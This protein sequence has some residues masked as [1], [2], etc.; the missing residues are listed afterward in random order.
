MTASQPRGA[1]AFP[2]VTLRT[3][4]FTVMLLTASTL[5]LGQTSTHST[6]P[7]AAPSWPL[8]NAYQTHFVDRSGR[9][10]D[11]DASD[12]TTSEGQ[13]Y[14]MF[15]SLVAN[16]P[17]QFDRLLQWTVENLA[18]GD[19]TAHLPAWEWGHAPDGSWRILDSNS[20]A[21]ADLWIAYTLLQAS[22]LWHQPRYRSL[23]LALAAQIAQREVRDIPSLGWMLLPAC[24]GFA[25]STASSHNYIRH[26][27]YILNPSYSPLP[28]LTG[29]AND[30]PHGPW[31]SIANNLPAFLARSSVPFGSNRAF[32]MDWVSYR[33]GRFLPTVLLPNSPLR[34]QP[35]GSYDAIRVYL[36]AGIAP[37]SMP[38]AKAVLQASSGMLR[39]LADHA[40][41]PR[42]IEAHG[43][44]TAPDGP[45]GFSAAVLP[46]LVA[47]HATQSAARQQN[48]LAALV[49]PATGLYGSPA[50]YYDQN[51][52][53]FAEGWQQHRY[54]FAATGELLTPWNTRPE[55]RSDSHRSAASK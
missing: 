45:V 39:Y 51:L 46:Y 12:R 43:N 16:D 13:A 5:A 22:A 25:V 28:V 23:G 6:G 40:I 52:A 44:I 41:P 55:P 1:R 53:L 27:F 48:R 35:T 26:N 10:I 15:F 2:L 34:A 49:D 20:A 19:L 3:I 42:S 37:A 38:G 24:N 32:A 29:M 21:D 14:A 33:D 11:H 50:R 36:W 4:A 31:R 18:H 30:D 47:L 9:V 8:W 7:A 17:G 54:R